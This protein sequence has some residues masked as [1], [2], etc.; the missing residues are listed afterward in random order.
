[1]LYISVATWKVA[2]CLLI[3]SD[4][5]NERE[6]VARCGTKTYPRRNRHKP[7]TRARPKKAGKRSGTRLQP[8][9]ERNGGKKAARE[10]ILPT[11]QEVNAAPFVTY[12]HP[13]LKPISIC[14]LR[15][16]TKLLNELH[17]NLWVR[18]QVAPG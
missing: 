9:I 10:N 12:K 14:A 15:A 6:E 4:E 16:A 17:N 11:T 2:I 5:G 8:K 1:M 7:S 13:T 18:G 3:V